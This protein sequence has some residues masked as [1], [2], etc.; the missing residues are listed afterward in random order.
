[1]KRLVLGFLLVL[2]C[3]SGSNAIAV[4]ASTPGSVGI[5]DQRLL[6]AIT[7]QETASYLASPEIEVVATL[8]DRIGSP[9]GEYQ[10]EFMWIVPDVRGLYVF[11]VVFPGPGTFQLTLD[12]GELGDL[13]PLG[14]VA[15]EDPAMVNVGELAPLSE[16]RTSD[17][18][19]I[20]DLSSDP[21][22][23]PRFYEMT[24]GEAIDAGPTV[25]VFATPAWCTSES[26][27]P[28]LD[29]VQELAPR[30]PDLNFVHVE[31]YE[32]IHVDTGD[33]L[34]LVPAVLEWAL[35]S[36]PWV[37]VVDGSG[38]VTSAFSGVA[39]EAELVAAFDAVS[40]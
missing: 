13:G 17:E 36:E 30:F 33:D 34:E 18:Y 29:Q 9:L 1:M 14:V 20:G 8:R 23:D 21:D 19:P 4:V 22:P 27:G 15:V 38:V 28:M 12:A 40:S 3:G 35:P 6:V 26:C 31:I 24:V 16:T 7:D 5:G 39:S 11:N 37:F 2:A 25:V 10:G 32:D